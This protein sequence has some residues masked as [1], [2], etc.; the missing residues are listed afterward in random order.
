M[1][2]AAAKA[3]ILLLL[4]VGKSDALLALCG[5]GFLEKESNNGWFAAPATTPSNLMFR[6][7][8]GVFPIEQR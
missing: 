4:Q 5:E 8:P 3:S 2:Y 6:R 1:R 7:V